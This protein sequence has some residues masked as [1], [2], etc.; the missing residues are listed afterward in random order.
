M[1]QSPKLLDR[2]RQTLR[3]E[4]KSPRTEEAYIAWIVR[5][6]HFHGLRTIQ[7][8]LGHSDVRTTMI[9]THVLDRGPHGVRSPLEAIGAVVASGDGAAPRS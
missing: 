4:H 3:T 8:L 6:V 5:F 2:V 1:D 9:Y 7:K